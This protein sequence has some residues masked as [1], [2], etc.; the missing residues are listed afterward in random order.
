MFLRHI[1][2]SIPK[3]VPYQIQSGIL[4]LERQYAARMLSVRTQKSMGKQS[5]YWLV[6]SD[7]ATAHRFVELYDT[8]FDC[9][10]SLLEKLICLH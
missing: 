10:R 5:N 2:C 1:D 8:T 4:S 3:D 7:Y 9:Y 6:Y